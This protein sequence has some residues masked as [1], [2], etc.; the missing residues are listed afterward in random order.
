MRLNTAGGD[1]VI[2]GVGKGKADA[3]ASQSISTLLHFEDM[4]HVRGATVQFIERRVGSR[5]HVVC[6][7]PGMTLVLK[8]LLVSRWLLFMAG[9][10]PGG[11]RKGG[12][13]MREVVVDGL[14]SG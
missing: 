5:S 10:I 3:A 4:A 8:N 1:Q 11:R 6:W 7:F 12:E 9:N 2:E 14:Y 13:L